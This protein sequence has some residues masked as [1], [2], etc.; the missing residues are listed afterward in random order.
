M[1]FEPHP[2]RGAHLL[3][4]FVLAVISCFYLRLQ[5]PNWFN[6]VH[7]QAVSLLL[8]SS[9]CLPYSSTKI[10]FS[11]VLFQ[12]IALDDQTQPLQHLP[13]MLKLD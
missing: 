10:L 9:Y 1:Q 5:L 7:V 6:P 4:R 13:R 2:Q 8:V 11:S 12:L 3:T